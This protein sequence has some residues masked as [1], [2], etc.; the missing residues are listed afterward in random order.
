[1]RYN[2]DTQSFLKEMSSPRT[3]DSSPALDDVSNRSSVTSP[4]LT[5]PE[6]T[7]AYSSS[8]RARRR[9][10][11]SKTSTIN[12]DLKS[13]EKQESPKREKSSLSSLDDSDFLKTS[14]KTESTSVLPSGRRSSDSSPRS[15]KSPQG[16][17]SPLSPDLVASPRSP[18]SSY[19]RK[20]SRDASLSPSDRFS[21]TLRASE[22]ESKADSK[23]SFKPEDKSTIN[24]LALTSKKESSYGSLS[25]SSKPTKADDNK[26]RDSTDDFLDSI[27]GE[28]AKNEK[29]DLR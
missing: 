10:E 23:L 25:G 29:P 16:R 18:L 15:S 27:F 8:S 2:E 21:K 1:M 3:N 4:K 24:G 14:K 6:P 20:T 7:S 5:S 13:P 11:L 17:L 26:T 19:Q 9:N 22:E 12:T 28:K